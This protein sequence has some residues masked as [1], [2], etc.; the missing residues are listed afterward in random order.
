MFTTLNEAYKVMQLQGQKLSAVESIYQATL[1]SAEALHLSDKIGNFDA[2]KEAD[3]V[4]VDW[5]ITPLQTLRMKNA[6]VLEDRI[7]LS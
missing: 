1:G 2:G 5:A 6:K 7:L 4:L 3:F